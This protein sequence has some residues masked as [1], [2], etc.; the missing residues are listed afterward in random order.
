MMPPPHCW[1]FYKYSSDITPTVLLHEVDYHS[2]LGYGTTLIRVLYDASFFHRFYCYNSFKKCE[3]IVGKYTYYMLH[4]KWMCFWNPKFCVNIVMQG[5]SEILNI[6]SPPLSLY[7]KS[8]YLL[9]FLLNP[10][11]C[12]KTIVVIV[13]RVEEWQRICPWSRRLLL[14]MSS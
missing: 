4:Y 13:A 11:L 14:L 12:C 3:Q 2:G 6:C 1:V 7:N 8:E 5:K 10:A 9:I